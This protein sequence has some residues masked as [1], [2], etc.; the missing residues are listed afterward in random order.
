M[1]LTKSDTKGGRA[2]GK[3]IMGGAAIATAGVWGGVV[4]YRHEKSMSEKKIAEKDIMPHLGPVP[5]DV[6]TGVAGIVGGLFLPGKMGDAALGVGIGSLCFTLA[7]AGQEQ[8]RKM[9]Q[10]K[11]KGA[12]GDN[13][14]YR[15]MLE[16]ARN[17]LVA[18]A[19]L[20]T[21][22]PVAAAVHSR[23]QSVEDM[24]GIRT[25]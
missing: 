11:T 17:D 3:A 19:A 21:A 10:P 2:V 12:S 14:P 13:R 5:A 4:G 16:R 9:A 18:A 6:A 25:R 1:Y 24:F 7:G 8:G 20:P 22:S 23:E 15:Q